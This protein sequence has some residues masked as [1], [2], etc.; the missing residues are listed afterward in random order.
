MPISIDVV[1]PAY[2]RLDLTE[3]CLRHLQ[4]QTVPH[5]SIVVDNGSTD[6]TSARLR[7]QWTEVRVERFERCL[8]FAEACNRGVAV[9]SS[10]VIVLL[11]NDVECRPDFLERLVAPLQSD[12][13]VGAVAPLMLQPGE[14]AI[15]S[16]GLCADSTL[17]GFPRLNG[18]PPA[19]ANDP[20]PVL[21][22]PA[23]AAA[24]YRRT[25][26][27]EVGG[28]DETMFAYMEDFDLGLRL[29]I[30]GWRAVAVIDAVGV[31]LGSATH[32]H[33]SA[34]QRRLGAFG[35]A[36]LMRRYRVLHGNHALR[37]LCTEALVVF[38]DAVL[39]RDLAALSGRVAGWR[40][41]RGLPPRPAP[42]SD[43]IDANIGFGE[44]LALRGMVYGTHRRAAAGR[45][46]LMCGVGLRRTTP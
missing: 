7:E 40:A 45:S 13:S 27:C 2:N 46:R 29:R 4:A 14:D 30:A 21:A 16:V 28:L 36:Y 5:R 11:N 25:A 15:D 17:A 19:R 39:M 24:A 41:A 9:G 44:S 8:G 35:R 23:G 10:D 31:H 38:G 43:A 34:S 26:W 1:I 18:L 42:P 12:P 3:S 6:G 32:G 37:T 20:T 33:R 22:G